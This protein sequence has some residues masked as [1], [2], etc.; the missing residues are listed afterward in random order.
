M[1]ETQEFFELVFGDSEGMLCLALLDENRNPT[2]QHFLAWPSQVE[3]AMDYIAEHADKDIYFCPTLFRAPNA[4]RSSVRSTR[5]VYG[6]ADTCPVDTLHTAPS[7][8]VAT[9]EE[10]THVYWI[11]EDSTDPAL[12]EAL[13][14]GVSNAHPKKLTGFDN[15]WAANKL[16]RVPGSTNTN[17]SDPASEKYIEGAEPFKVTAEFDGSVF[18]VEDFEKFY[19]RAE[20][21]DTLSKEMGELP[22]Y[23]EALNSLSHTSADLMRLINKR[24]DKNSVGSE[25]LFLL[26]QELF[27]LGASDEACFVICKKSGL[28]KFERDGRT[29]A[30][31]LLWG[32]VLRARSK[33]D[34]EFREVDADKNVKITVQAQPKHK[35]I[36]FLSKE[37]KSSLPKTFIDEYVEWAAS[38]TD[39]AREYH[40]AGAFTILSTIFSDFGHAVPKFG[41][42]P[43]NLWFMVLGDTTRSRKSTTRSQMLKTLHALQDEEDYHYDLG[44]DFTG[45]GLTTQLLTRANRSSLVH[46]DEVQDFIDSLDKKSYL[47]GLRGQMTELYD[48]HVNGKL[49]ASGT[50]KAQSSANIALTMYM[51]GIREAVADVLTVKDFQSGFLTRFIY[52]EAEPPPRTAESDAIEQADSTER[53]K[54]F[55]FDNFVL[56]LEE[57][58]DH[59]EIFAGG[60][61]P[62]V[63]V[64]CADDAWV[65][66]NKFIRDVMDEAEGTDKSGIIEAASQRLTLSILKAAT[67]IAMSECREQ[68]EMCDML[69]AINYCGQWF[70]H[71]VNMSKKVSESG[72]TR[73]LRELEEYVISYGGSVEWEKAYR[74][75]KTEMKPREF[76]ELVNALE[77]AGQIKV[78]WENPESNKKGKR[79]IEIELEVN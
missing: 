56:K 52:V 78:T 7:I 69:S 12:A 5:V 22:S 63:P 33:S 47:S 75:F 8:V 26:Q 19:P 74:H 32:D 79:Y 37:E 68:V 44:S 66:L 73:R 14:H 35:S 10:K 70:T 42:L 67:L 27:R 59:W 57:A 62:T 65:R 77:E 21:Q 1:I 11:L 31:E 43:L 46:L 36:D 28:N 3:E 60:S 18:L 50:T 64:P 34:M 48:G 38:K 23:S 51:M 40:V 2:H 53:I 24:Y 29:N 17:Y 45:E 71:L 58:R 9:S 6:D 55:V 49:R 30:D 25:A 20:V 41:R 13:A 76:L 15:G 61:S 4:R 16:L 39:A 72:W 54:D